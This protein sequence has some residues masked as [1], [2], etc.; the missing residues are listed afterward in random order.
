MNWLDVTTYMD[1]VLGHMIL[2]TLSV[3]GVACIFILVA[4][5]YYQY[6]NEKTPVSQIKKISL[7]I[8]A[9][10]MIWC[11]VPTHDMILKVKL[12]K[13]KNEVVTK[14][15]INAGVERIDA[16]LKKL[17]CKYIGGCEEK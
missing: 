17:E 4:N 8:W 9:L 15:N 12:S 11:T 3:I 7:T 16:M 5:T 6:D 2:A 14:E 1:Q 10:L 13:I